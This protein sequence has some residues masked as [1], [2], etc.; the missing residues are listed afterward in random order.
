MLLRESGERY[1]DSEDENEMMKEKMG[2]IVHDWEEVR[3]DEDFFKV[4]AAKDSDEEE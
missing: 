2:V 3:D 4:N 1:I